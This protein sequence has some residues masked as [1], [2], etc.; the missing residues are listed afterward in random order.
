MPRLKAPCTFRAPHERQTPGMSADANTGAERHRERT[1]DSQGVC[2]NAVQSP[3][4]ELV[5]SALHGLGLLL[6]ISGAFVLVNEAAYQAQ[7]LR[8]FCATIFA[9]TMVVLY[10]T[11]TLY[12][13]L[14]R[15]SVKDRLQRLDRTAITFLIAG[16]YTPVALLMVRGA[17]GAFLCLGEWLL[18][19]VA[20]ALMVRDPLDFPRRS[21]W[22]YQGMGWLTALGAWPL[23]QHT[24]MPVL[25]ALALG[26]ACYMGGVLFLVNDRVKYFH[27]ISHVCALLGTAF[28]FWAISQYLG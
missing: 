12:H 24:A 16:T 20:V 14:E 1:M 21:V 18:V 7:A 13:I 5:N 23:F 11:S 2:D 26:G 25:A 3:Q 27:A 8:L 28:Q 6:A 9:V 22:L 19:A 15:G 10:G 4:E 17:L